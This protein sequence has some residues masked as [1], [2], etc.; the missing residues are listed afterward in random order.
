MPILR[1]MLRVYRLVSLAAYNPASNRRSLA[2]GLVGFKLTSR[3]RKALTPYRFSMISGSRTPSLPERGTCILRDLGLLIIKMDSTQCDRIQ[4]VRFP[5]VLL[6]HHVRLDSSSIYRL[7]QSPEKAACLATH[8]GQFGVSSDC[9]DIS[10][11]TTT[12]ADP[13]SSVFISNQS[14]CNALYPVPSPVP[15]A[16]CSSF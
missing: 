13:F 4:R 3:R 14:D 16:I 11:P 1:G 7:H 2:L 5:R 10:A 9:N 15:N 8:S 12:L 6:A